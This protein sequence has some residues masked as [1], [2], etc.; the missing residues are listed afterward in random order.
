MVIS[1]RNLFIFRSSEWKKV[2][3]K[4]KKDLDLTFDENGE[5]W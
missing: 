3:E 4:D 1:S 2:S 5:F